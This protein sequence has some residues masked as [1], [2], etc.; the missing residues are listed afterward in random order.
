MPD[1]GRWNGMDQ[2]SEIYASTSPFAYVVNNPVSMRDPDGRWMDANG[3]IDTSGNSNPFRDMAQSRMRMNEFLGR[4]SGEGGA[5]GYLAFGQTQAYT[6]L[7][8]AFFNKG[9][10]G[11]SNHGGALRWWTSM[12]DS[13]DEEGNLVKGVGVL[14]ILMFKNYSVDNIDWNYT[15][16]TFWNAAKLTANMADFAYSRM[17]DYHFYDGPWM[18]RGW[19]NA[20]GVWNDASVLARQANGRFVRGVAGKRIAAANAKAFAGSLGGI[21]KKASVIGYAMDGYEIIKDGKV[22]VGEAAKMSINVIAGSI[23]PVGWAWMA[24]DI[25]VAL[26][27]NGTGLNDI[28]A[29]E[30]DSAT[31]GAAININPF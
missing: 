11:I 30:I 23:G 5:G 12:P 13:Y 17:A 27:N 29:S 18:K 31:G 26:F 16:S 19:R 7:M 15:G 21:A 24:A 2:L 10:V 3:H 22:T 4:H 20:N 9:E 28:I 8:T 25:G 14:G 1:L 6:D